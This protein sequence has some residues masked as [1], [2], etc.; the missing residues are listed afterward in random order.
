MINRISQNNLVMLNIAYFAFLGI[1]L[2]KLDID[3]DLRMKRSFSLI[4]MVRKVSQRNLFNVRF[5]LEAM[6]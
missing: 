4:L 6:Y 5:F 1:D 3:W 2:C